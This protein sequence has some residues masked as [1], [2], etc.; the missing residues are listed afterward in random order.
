MD[1]ISISSQPGEVRVAARSYSDDRG[2]DQRSASRDRARP[3]AGGR[4]AAGGQAPAAPRDRGAAAGRI[5]RGHPHQRRAARATC[6]DRSYQP[7]VSVA[8]GVILFEAGLRLSFRD[9]TPR[10]RGVVVRLVSMG[11]VVTW[12]AVAGSVALLFDGMGTGRAVADRRDPGRLGPDG[13]AAAARLHPPDARRPV[14]PEVG[15]RADRPARGAARRDRVPGRSDR[16]IERVAARSDA[17]SASLVGA[18]VGAIGAA[19]LW[20]LLRGCSSVAPRQVVAV[21]ARAD[22]RRAGRRPT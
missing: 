10:I 13:R 21:V 11:L 3:G 6:W 17:R 2:D 12:L 1:M 19:I 14:G 18:A 22:R 9:V 8:V 20:L 15:G 4:L 5:H 16:R 7:F